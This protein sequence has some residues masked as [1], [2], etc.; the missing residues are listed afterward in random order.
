MPFTR[1]I[2]ASDLPHFEKLLTESSRNDFVIGPRQLKIQ[3]KSLAEP[4]ILF[5]FPPNILIYLG[6]LWIPGSCFDYFN[7]L[8]LTPEVYSCVEFFD[9]SPE[10]P[11]TEITCSQM[12]CKDLVWPRILSQ[13]IYYPPGYSIDYSHLKAQRS[14]RGSQFYQIISGLSLPS[15]N[16]PLNSGQ[17]GQPSVNPLMNASDF[18][19]QLLGNSGFLNMMAL[20]N[21]HGHDVD[22]PNGQFGPN[23]S[24]EEENFEDVIQMFFSQLPHMSSF[25]NDSSS[26]PEDGQEL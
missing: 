16:L 3:S 5:D 15:L 26:M 2:I 25:Q 19:S 14:K 7:P 4:L 11:L 24:N 17:G 12:N 1:P 23:G 8:I 18:F 21:E 10:N 6:E 13:T 22:G 20:E 9:Q